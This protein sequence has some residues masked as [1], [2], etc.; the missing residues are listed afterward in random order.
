MIEWPIEEDFKDCDLSD[1]HLTKIEWFHNG[2]ATLSMR[3]TLS[4]GKVSPILGDKN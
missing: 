4:N 1:V 3:L 2:H